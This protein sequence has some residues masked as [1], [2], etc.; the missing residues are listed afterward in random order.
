MS[1]SVDGKSE[2][3]FGFMAHWPRSVP[4]RAPSRWELTVIQ[5]ILAPDFPGRAA[6]L[7]QAEELTVVGACPDCPLV[8]LTVDRARVGPILFSDGSVAQG[9]APFAIEG[10][11]RDGMGYEILLHIRDGYIVE[12]NPFRGDSGRFAVLPAPL[13]GEVV[14]LDASSDWSD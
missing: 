7:A 10:R 9:V 2:I 8:E 11:D 5:R 14:N 1:D 6:W 13:A 3:T 12:L 4:A